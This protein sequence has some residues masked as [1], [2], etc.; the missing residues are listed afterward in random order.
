MQK[1]LHTILF[2]IFGMIV[3]ITPALA[4]TSVSFTPINVNI[5]EGKN[6]AFIIGINPQGA[7][8]YTAKTELRYPADLMEV[9][10]FTFANNWMALSQSDYDLTDNTNGILIKT[11][12]YPGGV[13]SPIVF[14][15]V[16]FLAKKSGNGTITLNNN[17]FVLDANNQ[18]DLVNTLTQTAVI[19]SALSTPTP[20][21]QTT[22]TI[23][24]PEPQE[25]SIIQE[26][27]TP[28]TQEEQIVLQPIAPQSLLAQIGGFMAFGTDSNLIGV[29][30]TLIIVIFV[31]YIIYTLI[32]KTRRKNSRKSR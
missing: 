23:P 8:K 31:G 2:G 30:I 6:F 19:I 20:K 5:R 12:G 16:S 1:S 13:S 7:K 4:A 10:S 11:A 17:S 9:K 27:K 22:P 32:E 14:G 21:I 18:N 15:T 29:L 28:I 26:Q 24:A 25:E 3:F